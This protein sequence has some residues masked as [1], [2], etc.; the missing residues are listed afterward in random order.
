MGASLAIAACAPDGDRSVFAPN[1]HVRP[2][3]VLPSVEA[4]SIAP[5]ST[6]PPAIE[7]VRILP[8]EARGP[9][10]IDTF[11]QEDAVV[12]VLWIV[13]NTASLANERER[14]V[15]QFDR[16][17]RVL[18]AANVDF[19]VGVTSTD[20]VSSA[21]DG[22]RLRG[23]VIDR[24]TMDPAGAFRRAV[25]FPPEVSARLEEG[26]AAMTR[27]LSPPLVNGENAGFLREDGALAVIVVSDEDDGSLGLTAQYVRFLESLKG[28][29][30]EVSTS[31]SAVVGPLPEGCASP[32]EERIFGARAKAGER[33]IEVANATGGFVESICNPDFGPFI[34]QIA[35]ALSGLRRFFP[36][37]AP[38]VPGSVRVYVDGAR[39]P[40]GSFLFDEAA[41]GVVFE[42]GAA[43]P[44]GAEVRIEYDVAV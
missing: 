41:R 40:D 32:G 30:R 15:L 35:I 4:P 12:D 36:I 14:L 28:P 22:G 19:H 42:L 20:L 9:H 44:P 8:V 21:A 29:G 26:L 5:V 37:S 2:E 25:D 18:L 24:R 7:R 38:P 6:L 17:F 1:L 27:A 11:V 13:D 10:Q 3:L 16:F 43:P 31:F 33:Y 34:D 23:G 39:V